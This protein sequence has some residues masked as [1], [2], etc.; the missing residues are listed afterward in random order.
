MTERIAVRQ[1]NGIRQRQID[2]S[3][4]A[5]ELIALAAKARERAYAPYSH[6]AVGAAVMTPSGVVYTGCNVENGVYGLTIC[7][8]RVAV[9]KAV[10][11]GELQ[12][13]AL[14]LVTE[15]MS[16]PCGACRQVLA[17]F[18]EADMPIIVA[19]TDGE[20]RKYKLGELLPASFVFPSM[21]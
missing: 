4:T 2:W 11:N 14:A 12:L 17:E 16:T 5:E 18:G 8:E 3:S 6:F 10:S 13:A 19:N 9:F 7:A 21:N 20:S 1:G 15:T